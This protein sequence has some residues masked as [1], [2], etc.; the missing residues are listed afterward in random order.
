MA[1]TVSYYNSNSAPDEF[2]GA[3][4]YETHVD[5]YFPHGYIADVSDVEDCKRKALNVLYLVASA[6]PSRLEEKYSSNY[7]ERMNDYPLKSYIWLI[8][9]FFDNGLITS[10]EKIIKGTGAGRINWSHTFKKPPFLASNGFVYL[11]LATE[12]KTKTEDTLTLIHDYCLRIALR[13][14]GWFFDIK[15][16]P[17]KI[18]ELT[19]NQ[20]LYYERCLLKEQDQAFSDHKKILL[21]HLLRILKHS[22]GKKDFNDKSEIGT[23]KFSYIWEQMIQ[24]VY[25]NKP[26]EQFFPN[27]I[28]HIKGAV[29]DGPRL[30]PDTVME[31]IDDGKKKLY[32]LDAK[33]Y[34]YG[35]YDNDN[36]LPGSSDVQKQITYG[37]HAK[38]R[39]EE[40]DGR[41][42]NAF[43][44]PFC[45]TSEKKILNVGHAESNWREN[46]E[47]HQQVHLLLMD[48][49]YL[50]NK[51][52]NNQRE[53]KSIE[54]MARIVGL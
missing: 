11:D 48:S 39:H 27:A 34:R 1:R 14:I 47:S 50:I 49:E 18:D 4:I 12:C 38:L 23:Y 41:I 19:D 33:Y 25:G 31:Y 2:V 13:E 5:F 17:K 3:R 6:S 9:D 53:E 42:K 10:F 35:L 45:S 15:N 46:N 51:F 28:W 37:D 20:K 52:L 8:K 54:E 32:I 43:I 7:G 40:Y 30:R 44:L 16:L 24:K 36:L 21:C 22:I 26:L 29:K